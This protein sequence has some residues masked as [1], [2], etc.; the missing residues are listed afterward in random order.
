M[1]ERYHIPDLA[2]GQTHSV[3]LLVRRSRF[4]AAIAHCANIED[5][6]AFIQTQRRR[7]TDAT[8]NCWAFCAGPPGH[9]AR[10]ACHDDGEP[11]GAAG[12]PML[13]V[14]LHSGVGELACVTTRYFGGVKLGTAGLIRAYQ[15]AVR[16]ALADL[17]LRLHV[18]TTIIRVTLNYKHLDDLRRILPVYEAHIH[19]E[20]FAE[21]A[22]FHISIPKEHLAAFCGLLKAQSAG[23]TSI[24]HA[25]SP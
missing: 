21:A 4:I 8:H 2:S 11:H 1:S 3:Q 19:R 14:L 15:D 24:E 6:R 9:T 7:Y 10:I 18:E 13:T 12:R 17:P 22:C 16:A 20:T 5:A 25:D 23:S